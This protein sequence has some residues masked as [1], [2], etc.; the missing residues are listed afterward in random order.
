M[1]AGFFD[2]TETGVDVESA[3]FVI[4]GSGAGG[5]AAARA[6]SRAGA[7]VVVLEEGPLVRAN[8]TTPILR[9][10]MNSI[11]RQGGKQAAFGKATTPILQGRCVGGTTFVNSAIVWRLPE[12]VLAKWHSEFGLADGFRPAELDAAYTTI[13]Q[14]MHVQPVVEGRTAGRQDLLMRKGAEAAGVAGRL[15]HR[16]EDGCKGSARCLFGCPNDAKQSTTINYLRRAVDD[17]AAVYAQAEVQR[18][19]RQGGR[20]VAV[21]G[22]I[23]GRGAQAGKTFRVAA[24][25]AIIV[26][27]S[28][29]QSPNLLR[30]SGIR[31][32][33]VGEHFM[34]HPGTTVMGLYPD[35][36]NMWLGASQGY[37]AIGMR[38]T[39]GVKFET[40]NVPPEVAAARLPGVGDRLARYIDRL[41]R[42][43]SWSI[44][45]RADA[46]GSIRPSRLFGDKVSYSLLP[47]D[48]ERMRMGMKKLAEMHFLAGAVE[49]ITGVHGLPEVLTSADQLGVYDSASL[50][51]RA[52]SLVATHL[53]GGCRAGKDPAQSVVDPQL[54]VWGVDGLY[55]M[56][57]SVF[58]T[59][60]GVNPQ[61]SIM[62]VATVAASRLAAA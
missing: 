54:K 52:Y 37:E 48:I 38:D 34:A 31:G 8:Q 39:L 2:A 40:I 7:N 36:V 49:V 43:T 27:A 61:H 15:L 17:G 29:I 42:V 22:K 45:L 23:G 1:K 28:A 16:N 53:F 30:K 19:E 51:P 56:D 46:Q 62:A 33:H 18:I 3:D 25:R 59:N 60:T 57:A 4:V 5:G 21:T 9:R 13:E 32:A 47:G 50:D 41:D 55:V 6:L 24:K 26:A 44:A 11:F 20:A 12:K 35:R 10:S 14:E 58:P